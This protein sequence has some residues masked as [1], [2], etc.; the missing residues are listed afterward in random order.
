MGYCPNCKS[1]L[2]CGCQKRK[3]TDGTSA[4]ENC[5]VKKNTEL[6]NAKSPAPSTSTS[7]TNVTATYKGPGTQI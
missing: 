5:V 7:P 6:A 1:R 2:T 3:A 4:C